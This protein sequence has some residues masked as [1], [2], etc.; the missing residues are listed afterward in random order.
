MENLLAQV[1]QY[2]S[3]IAGVN[4]SSKEELEAFRIKY[5]GTKGLVKS[6]M[7]EM[8]NVAPENKKEAGQVLNDFKLFTEAAFD[9]FQQQFANGI[10]GSQAAAIDVSL[11][12]ST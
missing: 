2:K 7:G 4:I 6:I 5:L 11:P 9:K 1:A 8:K 10:A 3:E 12:G